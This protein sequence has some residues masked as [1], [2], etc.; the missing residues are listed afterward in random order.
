[1]QEFYAEGYSVFFGTDTSAQ[2]RLLR[3]APELFAY[4]EIE[5]RRFT[6]SAPSREILENSVRGQRLPPIA[7]PPSAPQSRATRSHH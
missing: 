4:L 6:L 1:V 5:A 7:D 2:A 3:F